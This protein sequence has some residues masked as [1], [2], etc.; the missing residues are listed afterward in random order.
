MST[1]HSSH[2][3]EAHAVARLSSSTKMGRSVVGRVTL[4]RERVCAMRDALWFSLSTKQHVEKSI[5]AGSIYLSLDILP[6]IGKIM[7][8]RSWTGGSIDESYLFIIGP[9]H[10]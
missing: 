3:N 6:S 4:V 1:W 7:G 10:I 9:T 2:N 8:G 5:E